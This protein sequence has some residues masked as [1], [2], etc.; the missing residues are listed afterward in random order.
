MVSQA[1]LEI[2]HWNLKELNPGARIFPVDA[3]AGYGVEFL[4]DWLLSLPDSAGFEHDCLRHT[5]P[6]GVCSYCVGEQ[7]VG[8]SFQQGVVGKI[9]FQEVL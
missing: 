3:L 6:A 1:E 8:S 2:I 9:D 7:R 4:G 5:M